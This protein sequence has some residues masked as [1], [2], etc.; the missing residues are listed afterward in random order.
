MAQDNQAGMAYRMAAKSSAEAAATGRATQVP[1]DAP[2]RAYQGAE[3]RRSI[4]YRC[5]GKA[6]MYE[7]GCDARTTATFADISL[8]GCYVETQATYPVGTPLGLKLEANG[9][10][11]EAKGDVRVNYPYAGMGIALVEMTD[12]NRGRLKDLLASIIGRPAIVPS[13]GAGSSH[14]ARLSAEPLPA[15]SDPAAAVQA[16]VEFFSSKAT[17]TREDFHHLLRQ[18]QAARAKA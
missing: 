16:L 6:E 11:I 5:E 15:I 14:P 2:P 3:K 18:S 4:R 17:L 12:E 7:I 9:L 8:H 13:S 10:T 1:D